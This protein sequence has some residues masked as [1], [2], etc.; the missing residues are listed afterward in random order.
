MCIGRAGHIISINA[1]YLYT[2]KPCGC[3][4][5]IVYADEEKVI[6]SLIYAVCKL[7]NGHYTRII[8]SDSLSVS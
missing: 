2:L 3:C 1:V 6:F 4:I 8:K 7:G 5:S